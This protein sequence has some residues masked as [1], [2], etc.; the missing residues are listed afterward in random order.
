MY[1]SATLAENILPSVS[2]LLP[3]PPSSFSIHVCQDAKQA[4]HCCFLSAR[5]TEATGRLSTMK[6]NLCVVAL[7]PSWEEET[8]IEKVKMTPR[9]AV[10]CQVEEMTSQTPAVSLTAQKSSVQ[11]G[12][13]SWGENSEAQWKN[14][15]GRLLTWWDSGLVLRR[16]QLFAEKRTWI[17]IIIEINTKTRTAYLYLRVIEI[18]DRGCISSSP[19]LHIISTDQDKRSSEEPQSGRVIFKTPCLHNPGLVLESQQHLDL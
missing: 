8:F 11:S 10:K 17:N 6:W 12:I 7:W 15:A 9:H 14:N 13:K 5:W 3:S 2:P 1:K 16:R 18:L 4:G 19:L